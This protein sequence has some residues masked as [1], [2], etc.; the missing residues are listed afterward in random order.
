[1]NA[2]RS[3]ELRLLGKDGWQ[4]AGNVTIP[5]NHQVPKLGQ[6]VE[7]RYLYAFPESGSLYQPTYLGLRSDI[8]VDECMRSQLKFKPTEAEEE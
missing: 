5:P 1:V 7:V 2:Q 3:V 6:V 8:T 4:L